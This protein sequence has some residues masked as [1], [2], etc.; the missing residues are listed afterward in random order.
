MM[1]DTSM[2]GI[3]GPMKDNDDVLLPAWRVGGPFTSV[4]SFL[5][6]HYLDPPPWFH[7]SV[8]LCLQSRRISPSNSTFS[9]YSKEAS[10]PFCLSIIKRPPVITQHCQH[11]TR[12]PQFP[13][14]HGCHNCFRCLS[15]TSCSRCEGEGDC[16]IA[17]Q[18]PH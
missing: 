9:L 11:L 16:C 12:I 2:M 4:P 10:H 6:H 17:E 7:S 5:S 13:G 18:G 3:N 14:I 1:N 15:R 8:F